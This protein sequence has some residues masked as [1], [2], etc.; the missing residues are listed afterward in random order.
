MS[1]H[2]YVPDASVA[3]SNEML[4]FFQ[5]RI[6]F[7]P[8]IEQRIPES[9]YPKS[10]LQTN[11]N[12]LEWYIEPS[13]SFFTDLSSF[14]LICSIRILNGDGTAIDGKSSNV[15]VPTSFLFHALF[16]KIELYLNEENITPAIFHHSVLQA[17][18]HAVHDGFKC[19]ESSCYFSHIHH[20]P[21]AI[22]DKYTEE[23]FKTVNKGTDAAPKWELDMEDE[24]EEMQLRY[25]TFG[26]S[27]LVTMQGNIL[28]ISIQDLP[29]LPTGVS[30]RLRL[31]KSPPSFF[32]LCKN[33]NAGNNN[34][35]CQFEDAYVT[36]DRLRLHP[37][38]LMGLERCFLTSSAEVPFRSYTENMMILPAGGIDFRM[39]KILVRFLPE[40]VMCVLV[41][42][43]ALHGS[44]TRDPFCF[45]GH[46]LKSIQLDVS[47]GI[48]ADP[49]II[50]TDFNTDNGTR[51]A[52]H[53]LIKNIDE[54]SPAYH[55]MTLKRFKNSL[56]IFYFRLTPTLKN[57]EFSA[58]LQQATL[59]L[60]IKFHDALPESLTLLI[61]SLERNVLLFEQGSDR[62][63]KVIPG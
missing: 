27:Q 58:P 20:N 55:E 45:K 24:D 2:Q 38:T 34:F 44:W 26:R 54:G 12:F 1:V 11:S 31:I 9:S 8:E 57:Q 13:S 25:K 16:S 46:G 19:S 29:F 36:Y 56:A 62:R 37:Q 30:I 47:R 7:N 53:Q 40:I 41:P 50:H 4:N 51:Q 23:S 61:Y 52:Y 10:G 28:P 17:I 48:F 49:F 18:K 14:Q 21:D 43:E 42:T 39:D 15:V 6:R 32:L 60:T 5:R 63:I 33:G 59:G 35:I 22:T 3:V